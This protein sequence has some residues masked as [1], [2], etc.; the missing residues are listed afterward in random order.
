MSNSIK[1]TNIVI[2]TTT[3]PNSKISKLRKKNLINNFGKYN[4]PIIFNKGI[5]TLK[6]NQIQYQILLDRFLIILNLQ[7]FI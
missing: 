1:N 2:I 5:T 4:I 6:K 3:L 7:S